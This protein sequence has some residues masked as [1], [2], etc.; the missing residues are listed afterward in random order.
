MEY[1]VFEYK[2]D[3][4]IP[5]YHQGCEACTGMNEDVSFRS[6]EF[7]HFRFCLEHRLKEY[8]LH[9]TTKQFKIYYTPTHK[10]DCCNTMVVLKIQHKK[11]KKKSMYVCFDG[12]EGLFY[13]NIDVYLFPTL[14]SIKNHLE[15]KEYIFEFKDIIMPKHKEKFIYLRSSLLFSCERTFHIMYK[16]LMEHIATKR[17]SIHNKHHR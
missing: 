2:Y 12:K 14:K 17:K 10:Y 8:S 5:P 1:S 9:K 15:D 6:S 16:L 11:N 3:N 4:K 7:L 13:T